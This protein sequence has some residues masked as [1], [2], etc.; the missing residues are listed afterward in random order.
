MS[1]KFVAAVAV[2]STVAATVALAQGQQGQAAPKA[3]K[4]EVQKL[5]DG[6]K[7]DKGKLAHYCE[8]TKLLVQASA[9]ALKNENDPKLQD[10]DKQA[11]EIAAKL[12]PDYGRIVNAEMDEA[13]A[14]LLDDLGRSC[15]VGFQPPQAAP[16]ASQAD[17]QKLV[18]SIKSDTAKSAEFCQV[19]KLQIEADALAQKNENDPK[20]K[21]L[22]QQINDIA[23]KLGSDYGRIA[24][25]EMDEASGTLLDG[26]A[27]SCK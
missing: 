3:T 26:L 8:I 1:T 9:L 2:L 4:A 11:D 25:S 21:E 20:L 12:G 15:D 6:I 27:K 19:T 22:G 17:V 16:K 7:S 10:I 18:D 13:S 5:V 23:E 24:T 14:A